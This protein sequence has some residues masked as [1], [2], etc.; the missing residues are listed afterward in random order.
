MANRVWAGPGT[1]L[2]IH[3]ERKKKFPVAE[4]TL[5]EVILT[6]DFGNPLVDDDGAFLT[7][8]VLR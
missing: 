5:T 6:D 2:H 4:A 8:M 1:S 3:V 7:A